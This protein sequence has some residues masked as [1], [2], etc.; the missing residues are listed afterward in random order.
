VSGHVPLFDPI[1]KFSNSLAQTLALG[2]A[3]RLE[4]EAIDGRFILLLQ[5]NRRLLVRSS[6]K[7]GKT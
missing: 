6:G 5:P 4:L 2:R 3:G 7:R 1:F